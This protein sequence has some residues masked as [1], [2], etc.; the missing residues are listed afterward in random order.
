MIE[1]GPDG[2]LLIETGYLQPTDARRLADGSTLIVESGNH[3]VIQVNAAGSIVWQFGVTGSAGA[4]TTKVNSPLKA[5]RLHNGNT[6]IIDTGNNRVIE[7]RP[8]KQIARTFAAGLNAPHAATRLPNGNT[9]I[10]DTGNHRVVEYSAQ[11]QLVRSLAIGELVY[12]VESLA[13]GNTL[14]AAGNTI[15]EY[16]PQGQLLR[17]RAIDEGLWW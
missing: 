12:D 5:T 16:S 8:N 3:R 11:G 4:G 9:M 2:V 17:S 13:N 15:A 1:V 10:A 6:L 7:V 14:I